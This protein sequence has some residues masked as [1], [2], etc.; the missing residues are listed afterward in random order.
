VGAVTRRVRYLPV[1]LGVSAGLAAVGAALGGWSVGPDGALGA[2]AGVTLVAVSYTATTLAVAW[3]DSVN[4]RM[5]LGVGLGMYVT[6]FSLF[7]LM[8]VAVDAADWGGMTAMSVGI[9][10]AIVA[11]LTA[12]IWWTVRNSHPYAA[13]QPATPAE[14]ANAPQPA[15]SPESHG[16]K[17]RAPVIE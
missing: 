1:A 8:M 16:L 17:A 6:K 2:V 15:S 4:P 11:W 9:A 12:Q 7:G 5:V 3:A 10:V 13:S 14:P